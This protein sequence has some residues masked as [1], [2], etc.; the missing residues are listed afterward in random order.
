MI[1][2]MQDVPYHNHL[3]ASDVTQSIHVLLQSTSLQGIFSP[4]ELLSALLAC[5]VHD[6]DHPGLSNQFL[7]NTGES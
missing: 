7:V 2:I 6:V 5:C 3:H 4:L 1:I